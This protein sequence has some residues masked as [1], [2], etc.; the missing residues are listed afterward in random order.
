MVS[1][2]EIEILE[3][4]Y[5]KG[6]DINF[7]DIVNALIKHRGLEKAPDKANSLR[8]KIH[9]RLQSLIKEGLLQQNKI[10][11]KDV[12]YGIRNYA[13]VTLIL[14]ANSERVKRILEEPHPYK[15]KVSAKD[16]QKLA[17]ILL[18]LAFGERPLLQP[19][20]PLTIRFDGPLK[21]RFLLILP[22]EFSAQK[23]KG[24]SKEEFQDVTNFLTMAFGMYLQG[25]GRTSF[26]DT[27]I[28][29]FTP[30]QF[31][32]LKREGEKLDKT[33]YE[34]T[35]SLIGKSFLLP[36]IE[37]LPATRKAIE[38]GKFADKKEAYTKYILEG[39]KKIARRLLSEEI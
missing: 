26:N 1:E 36:Q 19:F 39:E 5:E 35:L 9:R 13:R 27:V 23:L 11:H 4:L 17:E 22:D 24:L 16:P 20:A 21:D 38:M 12:R 15:M 3:F 33:V 34:A 10:S 14:A 32:N 25:P 37:Q 28:I 30:K 2:I 6:Q 18:T 7:V 29:K 8:T 31:E